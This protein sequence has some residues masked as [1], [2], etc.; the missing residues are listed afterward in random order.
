MVIGSIG[1]LFALKRRPK[2]YRARDAAYAVGGNRG[3][4]LASMPRPYPLTRQQVVVKN[5]AKSCGIRKGIS[6]SALMAA[7]ADCVGPTL[8][9]GGGAT[10]FF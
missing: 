8:R 5:T 2:S 7:M 4:Y 3:F 6:K 9:R 1:G 10:G